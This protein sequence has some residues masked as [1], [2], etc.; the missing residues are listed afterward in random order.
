M[1]NCEHCGKFHNTECDFCSWACCETAIMESAASLGVNEEAAVTE[2][3]QI[4]GECV[5]E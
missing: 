1:N 3:L 2:V 4:C 5:A